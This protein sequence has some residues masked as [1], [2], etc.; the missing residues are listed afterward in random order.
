MRITEGMR[1]HNVLVDISRAQERVMKAEQQV[2]S[3]KK[4]AVPS[5]NPGAT[6]DI[7]RLHS[8]NNEAEQYHRNLTFARSRLDV[9]DGVLDTIQHIVERARTLGQLGFSDD[10]LA[11]G[12]VTE[13][14]SLRDQLITASNTTHAGR[15]IFS[16][17]M[18]TTQPYVKNPDSSVTY[19]GNSEVMQLQIGRATTV[20]IQ[21]AGDEVFTGSTD[22][23]EV[24]NDLVTAMQSGDQDGMNQQVRMLEQYA[25]SLAVVRSKVGGYLN[26]TTDIE[27]GLAAAKLARA[28]ELTQ[29]EAADLA[30]AISELSMSQNSLQATLAV[31][32]RISQLT[33]LDFLR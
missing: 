25:E 5:D 15:F 12:Y 30:V 13:V 8:E 19:N 28:D 7:L 21:F 32:A 11:A 9:T 2:S 23:F 10:N 14:N 26:F 20:Q 3:G 16:G 17:S 24:M 29:E 22:V 4:L 31:G 1:Y 18:T 27:N 33:I 6:A